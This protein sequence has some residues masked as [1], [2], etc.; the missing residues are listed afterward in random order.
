MPPQPPKLSQALSQVVGE[1]PDYRFYFLSELLKRPVTKIADGKRMGRVKDLVVELSTPY[2][3]VVGLLVDHG[4]GKPHEY[5]LWSRVTS[6][7]PHAVVVALQPDDPPYRPYVDQPG[8]ILLNEHLMRQTILDIDGRRTK[9]VHDVHLLESNG[10][11]L[12][13][14]VDVSFKGI[15]RRMGLSRFRRVQAQLISWRIFRPLT[16]E[17]TATDTV[18]L[19]VTRKQTKHM[20]SDDL[21]AALEEMKRQE[22]AAAAGPTTASVDLPLST[23]YV[24]V[25]G[26]T[27]ASE[28]LKA[29]RAAPHRPDN[30]SAL[31]V[32]ASDNSLRGVVDLAALVLAADDREAGTLMTSPADAVGVNDTREQIAKAFDRSDSRILPVVDAERRLVGVV[33]RSKFAQ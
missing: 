19:T 17:D 22:R 7:T 26:N 6:L 23:D 9:V 13:V 21:T 32:V 14:H 30:V 3:Q 27:T 16:V 28:L 25:S 8:W 33:S 31:Y 24:A 2:P 18:M 11:M 4:W 1:K 29:L 10:R 15:M 5:V 12:L 20:P